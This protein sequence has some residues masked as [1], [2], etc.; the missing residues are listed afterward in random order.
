ML[1][2]LGQ[3]RLQFVNQPPS[4]TLRCCN[5]YDQ[6][7]TLHILLGCTMRRQS[8]VTDQFMIKWFR[9]NTTGA[10]E[11]LG[12][13]DPVNELGTD[14]FS[15]YHKK[16]L[17]SQPYSL[18]LLG[19]YWCQMINTTTADPDQR[20]NVFTLLAPWNYSGK[21]C[22]SIP[23]LKMQ[24]VGNITCAD[25]HSEQTTML[26]APNGT[27]NIQ[28]LMGNISALHIVFKFTV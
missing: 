2:P 24:V 8:G 21:T 26:P 12:L 13:G 18:S 11:N 10:V 23:G 20:S 25:Q 9:E 1:Y 16:G 7:E 15:Q 22:S 27:T 3:C 5:P 4:T 17:S 19:K 14:H 6:N 28:S